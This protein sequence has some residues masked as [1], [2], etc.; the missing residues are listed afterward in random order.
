[1]LET[2][3]NDIGFDLRADGLVLFHHG[4]IGFAGNVSE[5]VEGNARVLV[6]LA[7]AGERV[8]PSKYLQM[9][10]LSRELQHEPPKPALSGTFR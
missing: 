8:P 7:E 1:M 10:A 2:V 4:T 6:G 9:P 5:A 3:L